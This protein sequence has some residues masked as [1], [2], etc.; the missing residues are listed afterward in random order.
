M[1]M[2]ELSFRI[3]AQ[4]DYAFLNL[5]IPAGQTF[6]VEAS[7]MATMDTHIQMKTKLKGGFNRFL[8]GE[9]LFINEFTAQG[10]DG[11]IGFHCVKHSICFDIIRPK[12]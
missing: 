7:S 9:S 11:N 8:T 1:S 6:K 10:A 2:Q 5:T 12:N 4:P 3:E